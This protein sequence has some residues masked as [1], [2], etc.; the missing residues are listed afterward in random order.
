MSETTNKQRLKPWRVLLPDFL[1]T[2]A[3]HPPFFLLAAS[4]AHQHVG[5]NR[6]WHPCTS[7]LSR[8]TPRMRHLRA[9]CTKW[10]GPYLLSDLFG[11]ILRRIWEWNLGISRVKFSTFPWNENKTTISCGKRSCGL[12]HYL[13]IIKQCW[14]VFPFTQLSPQ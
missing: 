8:S 13:C 3:L 14:S 4:D 9:L 1:T 10:Q 5:K 2:A 11:A 12:Y 7:K 6:E